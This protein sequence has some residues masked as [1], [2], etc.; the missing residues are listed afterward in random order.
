MILPSTTAM[1]TRV[2]AG[3]SWLAH[4]SIKLLQPDD[5]IWVQD[6]HLIPFVKRTLGGRNQPDGFFLHIPFPVAA[7][8]AQHP[9][10]EELVKSLC[11]T[12]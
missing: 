5:V 6:Y 4:R 11:C 9:P 1:N 12:T 2:I 10:H 7:D 3:H 8:S